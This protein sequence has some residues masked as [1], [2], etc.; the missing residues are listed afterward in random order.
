MYV[1]NEMQFHVTV[2]T[3]VIVMLV[4]LVCD[5]ALPS[6][7]HVT[8]VAHSIAVDTS[9]KA[10]E[11]LAKEGVDC[12]VINLR[13]LRPL[14]TEAIISSVMKTHHLVTVEVGWPQCGVG[15]EVIAS[16]MESK[17]FVSFP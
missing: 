9:L 14:D 2:V 4:P 15:S 7:K 8:L 3:A 11:E 16:V 12:E 10:A 1:S 5:A 6:G 13:S 17:H